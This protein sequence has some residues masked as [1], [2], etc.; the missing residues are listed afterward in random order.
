M[1]SPPRPPSSG[2]LPPPPSSTDDLP[3]RPP[4]SGHLPPPP[5]STDDLTP[6]PPSSGHL[7][8]P[9]PPTDDLTPP[10]PSSGHLPP[11]PPP[12]DD[13]TPPPPSSGLLLSPAPSSGHLPPPSLSSGDPPLTSTNP[14]SPPPT[15]STPRLLNGDSFSFENQT[16]T[17]LDLQLQN[18]NQFNTGQD[19]WGPLGPTLSQLQYSP[20][21][22]MSAGASSGRWSSVEDFP[23]DQLFHHSY[24]DNSGLQPFC[25]PTTPGLS[26]HYPQTPTV[27]SPG[28]QMY[29]KTDRLGFQTSSYSLD[30]VV[31]SDLLPG[32]TEPGQDLTGLHHRA[33]SSDTSFQG[34]S[35]DVGS[36]GPSPGLAA[37]LSW[38]EEGGGGGGGEGGGRGGGGGGGRGG[39]GGRAGGGGGRAGGGGEGLPDWTRRK[40]VKHEIC[41]EV[42]DS[43]LLCT[44][45]K[46]DFRSLPALNGHMRSHS[47]F[48]SIPC[49][50]KDSSQPVQRSVSMVMPVSVPVQSRG[51]SKS[52]RSGQRRCSRLPPATGGAVLYRSLM[53]LEEEEGVARGD[54]DDGDGAV[55][56]GDGAVAETGGGRGHYTPPPMLCPLRAG[57]G[58]LCSVTT[59]RQQRAQTV[60][61]HNGFSDPVAVETARPAPE[62]LTSGII[63]PRINLGRGFQAEIPP[64]QARKYTCF[65]S[66]NALLLWTPWD[67]LECP[68]NQNRVETLLLM[69]RSS[70]VPGGGASPE[71]TLHVLSECRG[72]FQ[73]T[74]EKLLSTPETNSNNRAGVSWSAAE[75]RRLVK[76]LQLHHKD[77]SSVQKTVQTK[78]LSECV[79]FYYLWKKKLSLT[80]RTP[81]VLTVTLPDANG[82]RSS[83]SP[84]AS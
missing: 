13:L 56:D 1:T 81:A 75:R 6:P 59:R 80:A 32:Q 39:R 8:P 76:S 16:T 26:P 12:T 50:K 63:T 47:S 77:F 69:A 14:M 60:Q 19:S 65:N 33:G 27:S 67:E 11:P 36:T 7:P 24:H 64:L 49:L 45:C 21:G 51:A 41:S 79:H 3:P 58:L 71:H 54:D 31:T 44:V 10:P 70:V 5:S 74:V 57:L 40:Q 84:E 2:H 37:G 78:S 61:L 17:H 48:R 68:V 4:S 28:P 72:D 43:R 9:P 15:S 29:P 20:L 82:Q 66:H 38:R 55:A 46:R 34:R 53:H 73:L 35:K 62:T 22:S 30:D 83:G 23:S 25:S 52:G 42:P 18:Q